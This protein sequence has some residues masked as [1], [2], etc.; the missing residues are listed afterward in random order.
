MVPEIVLK[1][2]VMVLTWARLLFAQAQN[3]AL[4]GTL[5]IYL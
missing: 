4:L 5:N 1:T 3:R 2:D